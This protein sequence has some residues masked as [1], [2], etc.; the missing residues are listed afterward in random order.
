MSPPGVETEFFGPGKTMIDGLH[1]VA[2][3][4]DPETYPQ[5][6]DLVADTLFKTAPEE[7]IRFLK[8][9]IERRG[10][11]WG[12]GDALRKHSYFEQD[13]AKSHPH[14]P[15]RIEEA[16]VQLRDKKR[17]EGSL[18]L[19]DV[20]ATAYL[21]PD[22]FDRRATFLLAYE[23]DY[24][25]PRALGI[26]ASIKGKTGL[27]QRSLTKTEGQAYI[28]ELLQWMDKAASKTMRFPELM[29]KIHFLLRDGPQLYAA[30][31][32]DIKQKRYADAE[33]KLTGLRSAVD[34][35]LTNIEGPIA[36]QLAQ[37]AL[38]RNDPEKAEERL[39]AA[40]ML[41]SGAFPERY[42][43]TQEDAYKEL[44]ALHQQQNKTA[45][46]LLA[47]EHLHRYYPKNPLFLK[48]KTYI[49]THAFSEGKT[50]FNTGDLET[51]VRCFA[52]ETTVK[53]KNSWG[54]YYLGMS[55]H[56]RTKADFAQ[57]AYT[58]A[59]QLNPTFATKDFNEATTLLA[60]KD[61]TRALWAIEHACE[62]AHY[63]NK[64]P[65]EKIAALAN[66]IGAVFKDGKD[67]PKDYVAATRAFT[68]AIVIDDTN[69]DAYYHLG[70]I[71][72]IQKNFPLA[73][74]RLKHALALS[75][76]HRWA[77]YQ[78][79]RVYEANGN[80]QARIHYQKAADLG[81]EQA[82]AAL[83]KLKG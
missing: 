59:I 20:V 41:P 1:A 45:E 72:L 44:I 39:R 5:Y 34:R 27:T 7:G 79:A 74:Q 11:V 9:Y 77:H 22:E 33:T 80:L 52:L 30:A 69:P 53:P 28:A 56:K 31:V 18:T 23:L 12:L 68:A 73:E 55:E 48:H 50:A 49:E 40:V 71:G 43:V 51:A 36:Y 21:L 8:Q 57:A 6:Y 67:V 82:S 83:Q 75:P 81:L 3:E 38:K 15:D 61:Y 4:I 10:S 63:S 47:L 19:D 14:N 58:Q 24:L 29:P 64:A 62:V 42:G 46:A 13:I 25:E 37:I 54:W 16:L 60:K 70:T 78:L 2:V 65:Q 66:K 32:E 17:K 26:S 35:G 76:R